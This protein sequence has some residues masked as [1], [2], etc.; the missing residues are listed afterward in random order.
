[1][2]IAD[3]CA[4]SITLIA[5]SGKL[6]LIAEQE[7]QRELVLRRQQERRNAA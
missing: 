6:P 5:V 4:T 3:W 7:L 2:S 1:M